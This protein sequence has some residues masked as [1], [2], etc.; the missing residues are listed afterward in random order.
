MGLSKVNAPDT[1]REFVSCER[2]GISELWL[3]E[4]TCSGKLKCLNQATVATEVVDLHY[5]AL[6]KNFLQAVQKRT[7][8]VNELSQLRTHC[9]WL[10]TLK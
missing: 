4:K 3:R 7:C 9:T 5:Q 6:Q 1:R 10:A 2:V 8:P